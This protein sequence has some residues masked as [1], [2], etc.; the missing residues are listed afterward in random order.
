MIVKKQLTKVESKREV[1]LHGTQCVVL[2]GLDDSFEVNLE[3]FSCADR[4]VYVFA[5]IINIII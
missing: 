4:N 5:N 2:L 1:N 3:C